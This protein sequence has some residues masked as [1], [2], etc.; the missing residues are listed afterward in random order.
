MENKLLLFDHLKDDKLYM[1]G[2]IEHIDLSAFISNEIDALKAQNIDM[3][4]CR[5]YQVTF[6]VYR[7]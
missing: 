2:N 3:R 7:I 6:E 5:L 1:I 4:D